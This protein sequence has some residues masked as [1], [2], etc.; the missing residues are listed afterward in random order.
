MQTNMPDAITRAAAWSKASKRRVKHEVE[1]RRA[2][3]STIS[4]SKHH[5]SPS[6]NFFLFL[7]F[8]PPKPRER[9]GHTPHLAVH[10][11]CYPVN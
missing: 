9:L 11:L 7:Y 5:I 10:V 2:Y 4:H 6:F 1:D 8:F 3:E